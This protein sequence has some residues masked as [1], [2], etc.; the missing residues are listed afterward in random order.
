[1]PNANRTVVNTVGGELSPILAARLDLPVYQK[2]LAICQ[3]YICLPQG[4]ATFRSGTFFVNYTR[5]NRKAVFIPF[6]FSDQQSYLIEATDLKFRFYKDNQAVTETAKTITA[7]TNANPG[8]F[9]ITG[10]SYSNGDEVF[11]EGLTGTTG[12]NGRSYLVANVTANTFTLTTIFGDVIDTTSSGTYTGTFGTAARIYEIASPYTEEHLPFLQYAQNANTMYIA[13]QEYEPRKLTRTGHTSWTLATYV[14]T[15][16][17]IVDA[18]DYPR[19]VAFLDSAR[20]AFGGS[21]ARPETVWCSKSPDPNNGDTRFDN[22][23]D[24]INPDDGITFTLA[25]LHGKVDAIAWLSSTSKFLACGTF[26]GIRRIYGATEDEPVSPTSLTAKSVNTFGC[27]YS[28]PVSDGENLFYIQRGNQSMR[29]LEYDIQID[30]Y[31]TRDRHLVAEHLTRSGIKQLAYQQTKP[32]IIWVTRN[33]G[34]FVGLTFNQKEDLSGWHRHYIA[35]Q[36]VNDNGLTIDIGRVLWTGIM[37]R[38]ALGDQLWF[39][40]ERQIEAFGTVRTV[41]YM[42][43]SLDYPIRD[44]Y[45]SGEDT[46]QD[47]TNKD[48][49]DRRYRDAIYEFQKDAV[50]LDMCVQYNGTEVGIDSLET[51]KTIT[52]ATNAD[53]GVFTV[54]AHGFSDGDVVYLTGLAGGTWATLN[55]KFYTAEVIDAD[56]FSLI[57]TDVVNPE[58]PR[59]KKKKK[60][61]TDGTLVPTVAPIDTT[62]LATY[63][64][65]SG[66]VSRLG[67]SVTPAFPS[68]NGVTFTATGPIFTASMVGR[69]IWKSYDINGD[70][71][72]RAVIRSI[73]STTQ[74]SCDIYAAFDNSNTIPPGGWLMTTDSVSGLDHLNGETVGVLADGGPHV[75]VVVSNGIATLDGQYSIVTVG[76]GPYTGRIESLNVDVG[77]VTGSAQSKFR[78]LDR[79]GIRFL[80]SVGT[81][82]GLN[83]YELDQIPFKRELYNR[84]TPLF[85]GQAV[86]RKLDRWEETHKKLCIIH[87]TAT[88]STILSFDMFVDVSDE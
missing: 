63:T 53:P 36:H 78:N 86:V 30:G 3:N 35:G 42:A 71:G 76:Y 37:P 13:H 67:V 5:L 56:S 64:A 23:S 46:Y 18:N 69:E 44:D 28:L 14:R 32:D 54:T 82:F 6:Q 31:T 52:A 49:D 50:H 39:I 79:L 65:S 16:D 25:P 58:K 38:P 11:I 45:Y 80:N 60:K 72:G 24:G 48:N 83:V 81:Q 15:G 26:S 51:A 4:G 9:T 73:I 75:A 77:G 84:P 85:T 61:K 47:Y 12:L 41:E 70:G 17:F 66:T 27:A 57:G 34:R 1:M 29:S 62:G 74:A 43:D 55:N 87:K 59:G 20:L 8:V 68:G 22:F 7:M 88:P 2:G 33:D 10:H 19:A 21:K 40:V